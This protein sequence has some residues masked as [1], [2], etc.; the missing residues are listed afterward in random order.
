VCHR[1]RAPWTGLTKGKSEKEVGTITGKGRYPLLEAC[2]LKSPQQPARKRITAFPS[3]G[4]AREYKKEFPKEPG[5]SL[6]LEDVVNINDIDCLGQKISPG[7]ECEKAL[8]EKSNILRKQHS[9]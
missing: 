5:R 1:Q 4:P 9:G 3:Q 8:E 6:V 2:R 7:E